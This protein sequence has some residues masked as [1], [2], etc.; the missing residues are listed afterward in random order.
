MTYDDMSFI[1]LGLKY[2]NFCSDMPREFSEIMLIQDIGF[3]LGHEVVN[4]IMPGEV[5]HNSYVAFIGQSRKSRKN[6]AQK[7]LGI[8]IIPQEWHLPSEGSPEGFL[9]ELSEHNAGFQF[10]G[11]WSKELK[12]IK[13]GNYLS[14]FCEIKNNL[15]DCERIRKRLTGGKKKKKKDDEEEEKRIFV[16]EKPYVC[17]NTT[18]TPEV[19]KQILTTEM[20]VGGYIARFILC[21]GLPKPRPRGRLNSEAEF[22]RKQLRNYLHYLMEMDKSKCCFELSDDALNYFNNVV[23]VE[24]EDDEF[25]GVGSIAE[26]Y[27]DYVIKFADCLLVSEALGIMVEKTNSKPNELVELVELVKLGEKISEH[28]L[29]NLNNLTNPSNSSNPKYV[30]QF[31]ERVMVTQKRH[32]EEAWKILKPCL[33]YAASIAKYVDLERDMAKVREYLER[34]AKTKPVSHSKLLRDTGVYA[35]KVDEIIVT[36]LSAE[37]I[38]REEVTVYR[39]NNTTTKKL[40]YL[41]IGS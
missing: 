37:L 20:M 25:E 19:L 26:S 33:K 41:W 7:L 16:I 36:F 17:I 6:T 14:D 15:F 2:G 8:R 13:S 9:E 34:V 31:D 18:C 11:E 32:V 40:G 4:R 21:N 29:T 5:Y 24:S 35:R 38:K 3:A 39:K 10:M 12:G 27:T 28:N 23:V 30:N 1:G 22:I